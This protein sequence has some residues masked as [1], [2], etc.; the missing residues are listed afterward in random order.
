M[1]REEEIIADYEAALNCKLSNDDKEF[2]LNV[3]QWA[4]LHPK[5][6]WRDA[7]KEKPD[8]G[9]VVNVAFRGID[10]IR[11]GCDVYHED[12][13]WEGY[14]E[15]AIVAWMPIPELS[16]EEKLIN[17]LRELKEHFKKGE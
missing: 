10:K 12:F 15:D 6:P 4:D 3:L 5:N 17:G 7:K 13:G 14:D 9:V 16:I 1:T 11:Y 2:I 8:E